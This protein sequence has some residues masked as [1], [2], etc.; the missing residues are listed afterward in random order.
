VTRLPEAIARAQPAAPAVMIFLL[1]LHP[2][3]VVPSP[4]AGSSST[5]SLSARRALSIGIAA[6]LIPLFIA[7]VFFFRWRQDREKKEQAAHIEEGKALQK[8]QDAKGSEGSDSEASHLN[9]DSGSDT[10]LT[11]RK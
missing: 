7:C 1:S 10:G 2:D 3:L 9:C 5:T 4:C 8:A 6:A 11:M